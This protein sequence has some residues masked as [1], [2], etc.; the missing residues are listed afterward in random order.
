MALLADPKM[1]RSR[2]RGPFVCA[3]EGCDQELNEDTVKNDDPFCSVAC[4]HAYHGVEIQL[5]SRGKPVGASA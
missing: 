4:C 2:P 3:L 5:P 1:K